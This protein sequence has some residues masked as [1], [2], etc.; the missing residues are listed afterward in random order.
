LANALLQRGRGRPWIGFPTDPGISLLVQTELWAEVVAQ[1]FRTMLQHDPEPYPE[2]RVHVKTHRGIMLDDPAGLAQIAAWI[3]E[4]GASLVGIDPLARHMAG[5]EN[6]NRD[7]GVVVRAVDSLVERY[8]VAV[9]I[10][11]HP[12]KPKDGESR[13]GGDRLRGASA[14]FASADTVMMMDRDGDGFMLSFQ[15]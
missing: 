6:S 1:R 15:V 3:E 10:T 9:W 7:M 13:S 2:G 11:H 8:G 14:L 5:D 4:T 12:G